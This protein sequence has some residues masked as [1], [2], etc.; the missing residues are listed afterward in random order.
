MLVLYTVVR[1]GR[2]DVTTPTSQILL[3]RNPRSLQEFIKDSKDVLIHGK[4][5]SN[6]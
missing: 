5:H 3:G 1:L 6:Y 2:G 4:I